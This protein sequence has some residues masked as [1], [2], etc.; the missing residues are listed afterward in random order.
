MRK[1]I[2]TELH[3]RIIESAFS[4]LFDMFHRLL[5]NKDKRRFLQEPDMIC[6]F[7][8]LSI[9]GCV[10]P[11]IPSCGVSKEFTAISN[12]F[13]SFVIVTFCHPIADVRHWNSWLI[14]VVLSEFRKGRIQLVFRK[15]L[16]S[17]AS[18]KSG[19]CHF[20]KNLNK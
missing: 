20:N 15:C 17:R 9:S 6:R 1:D 7:K 13:H 12:S 2:M 19:F 18:D 14:Y 10:K 8:S 3:N 16:Q 4:P 5:L 11:G